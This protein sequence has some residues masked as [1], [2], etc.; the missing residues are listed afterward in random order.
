MQPDPEPTA[1]RVPV[2]SKRQALDW[3]LVLIS[4]GIETTIDH[5]GDYIGWGLLV[6]SQDCEKALHV[7][8]QYRSENRG[9]PWRRQMFAAGL[10]FDA[11]SLVWA[12]LVILFYWLSIARV[13]FRDAGVMDGQSVAQGEW[14]RLFTAIFLHADLAHLASNTTMGIVL[15]G[16]AMG[17]YGTGVGLLGAYLA[18]AGGN[19]ASWLVSEG[20]HWALGASGMIM[21]ALGLLAVQSLALWRRAP[22]AMKYVIAGIAGGVMLFVLLGMTPATDVMAHL[23]GFV[24]GLLLGSLLISMPDFGRTGHVNLMSGIGFGLLTML[25]WYLALNV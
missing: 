9:W 16:L 10:L 11:G 1:M 4:Q 5:A 8:R 25:T 24:T 14:W 2:R 12:A 19:L 15:I 21:G 17:R 22:H 23:G 18:G 6:A 3:S 7:L 13:G 20:P